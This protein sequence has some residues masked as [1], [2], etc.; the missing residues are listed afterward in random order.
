MPNDDDRD[1]PRDDAELLAAAGREPEAFA[2]LHRRHAEHLL[3]HLRR[4]S[5]DAQTALDLLA[6]VMAL[7]YERR[8]RY[9]S[10]AGSVRQWLFGIARYELLEHWRTERVRREA[11]C[12]LGVDVPTADDDSIA[13]IDELLD[14]GR[15]QPEL[16]R[17]LRLL[18][19]G[20]REAVI[21]RHMLDH[22]YDEIADRL[23]ISP[24]AARV[25]VHRGLAKLRGA[26][27]ASEDQQ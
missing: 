5:R 18:G 17:A 21:A 12:R 14:A 2:V 26:L 13:R 8:E 24:G 25:R 16:V 19:E 20:E 4:G 10:E 6:E 7:A 15:M 27:T 3:A 9:R 11:L 1:D 22:D 23:S